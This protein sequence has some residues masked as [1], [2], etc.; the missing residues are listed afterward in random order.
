DIEGYVWLRD[1]SPIPIAA[2]EGECGRESFR[3][4]IDQKALDVYQVDISRCGFTE[5][6]YIRARVEEIGAR[7]CNHCYTSPLTVAAS[8]HWLSTCKDAFLFEDCVEDSPLRHELTLEK[9]Q[10]VNGWIEVPDRPGLGVTLDEK[11]VK[12]YLVAESR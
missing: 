8:L 5:A 7:L 12:K 9:V 11:F 3:P 4:F 1:R 6:A 2:G 10:S